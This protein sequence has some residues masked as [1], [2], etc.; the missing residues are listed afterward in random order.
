[1]N[2]HTIKVRTQMVIIILN[3]SGEKAFIRH[4]LFFT[5]A[6]GQV[7]LFGDHIYDDECE[8]IIERRF[9]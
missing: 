5:Q 2:L 1:M 9:A 4:P 7:I 3:I 8:I 6:K